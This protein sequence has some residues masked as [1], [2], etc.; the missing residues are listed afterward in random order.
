VPVNCAAIPAT[1]IESELFGHEKGAFTGATGKR[2]GRFAMADGG[3]LFLDEIG[4]LQPDLQVK[5][6]RVLQEREFAPVGSSRSV[7]V[8][9]RVVAA[10][11]RDL[12]RAVADGTF[13]QDLF[14][15]LNVIPVDVPPLR[16]RGEDVVLLAEHFTR[17]FAQRLGRATAGP[18]ANQQA[19]LLAYDWP[20]NVR[21]LQNVI[22]RAVITSTDG[23]LNLSRALPDPGSQPPDTTATSHATTTPTEGRILTASQLA[24]L[25]RT[26][27]ERALVSCHGKV[28]GAGG[29]AGLLGMKPSTLS[30]RIK[31][32]GL[33]S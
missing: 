29:A 7:K 17:R 3:T 9:V 22:E 19:K 20:G 12:T 13:R 23:R 31:A 14:Y 30:S 4:E 33:K 5:L 21:E 18:D 1:L 10:T 16:A 32:L 27:I 26:N 6:L 25:E 24:D 8:D 28:S 11:H 2:L 15:R